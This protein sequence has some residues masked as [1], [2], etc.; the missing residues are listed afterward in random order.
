M[1][2]PSTHRASNNY[3]ASSTPQ[4][5][6]CWLLISTANYQHSAPVIITQKHGQQTYSTQQCFTSRLNSFRTNLFRISTWPHHKA[7]LLTQL[8][9]TAKVNFMVFLL[10]QAI[11]AGNQGYTWSLVSNSTPRINLKAFHRQIFLFQA[12]PP[13]QMFGRTSFG[14]KSDH[15]NLTYQAL[16]PSVEIWKLVTSFRLHRLA[17]LPTIARWIQVT[18]KPDCATI[19][20][21]KK[22][23][24]LLMNLRFL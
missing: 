1:D 19:T 24:G 4:V 15:G 21:S 14:A 9:L 17:F 2:S 13:F 5:W 22:N 20:D 12:S 8:Q 16:K 23:R 11:Y 10:K 6:T 7:F 3:S 18:S